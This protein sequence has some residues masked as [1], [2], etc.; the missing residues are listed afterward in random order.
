MESLENEIAN[1]TPDSQDSRKSFRMR[2]VQV[3][4]SEE[5]SERI[6]TF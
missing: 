1:Q 4:L 5:K 3:V 6:E 2:N